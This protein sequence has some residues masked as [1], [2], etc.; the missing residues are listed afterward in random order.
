MLLRN[1][2]TPLN[3]RYYRLLELRLL[4]CA[5]IFYFGTDT[6][7]GQLKVPQLETIMKG[8]KSQTFLMEGGMQHLPTHSLSQ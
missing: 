1:L 7:S 5:M 2:I 6:P 8:L 3:H 4:P